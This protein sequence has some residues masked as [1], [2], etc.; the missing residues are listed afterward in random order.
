MIIAMLPYLAPIALL[1][2]ANLAFRGPAFRPPAVLRQIEI[3]TLAALAVAVVSGLVV[4]FNGPATSPLIGVAG[5]GF[6]ARLDA[7]SAVMLLLVTFGGWVVVRFA[8]TYM[9]GE[10]QQGAFTGWLCATLAAVMLLVISGNTLQ[11]IMAWI[12]TSQ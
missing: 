12:V 5:L 10:A 11:L 9:D 6:A 1:V 2:A 3:A 8:A 4:V 7:V